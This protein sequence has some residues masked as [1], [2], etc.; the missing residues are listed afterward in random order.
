MGTVQLNGALCCV[1]AGHGEST[2]LVQP[3]WTVSSSLC[4][5]RATRLLASLLHHHSKLGTILRA[6]S[7][8][9]HLLDE[10]YDVSLHLFLTASTSVAPAKT[11][12]TTYSQA[13]ETNE[14]CVEQ[15]LLSYKLVQVL[16]NSQN[17]CFAQMGIPV[18]LT[19]LTS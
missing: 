9:F 5:T 17:D 15:V 4:C 19:S 14:A 12:L 16:N 8:D 7:H 13:M 11:V 6:R 10:E 1:H 2:I 18:Y 3:T